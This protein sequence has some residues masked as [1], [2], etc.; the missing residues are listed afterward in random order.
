MLTYAG[1]QPSGEFD[2]SLYAAS[3]S[4]EEEDGDGVEHQECGIGMSV[5][6]DQT[7]LYR[8]TEVVLGGA[9]GTQFTCFTGT[10]AHIL[11]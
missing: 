5:G 9:A 8:I 3:S 1:P 2:P 11:T 7:G 10:K 6:I 4:D